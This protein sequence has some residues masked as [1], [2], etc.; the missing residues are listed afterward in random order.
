VRSAFT[1]GEISSTGQTI[2]SG[3]T[4]TEIGSTTAASGGDASITYS[5]RSSADGYTAAIGSATSAT[6]TPPSGLT[7]TTSYRRYANDGTCNT[8]ATVSTGTWTVTVTAAPNAGTISGIQTICP[9]ATTTFSSNGDAGAWS[10]GST[11][12][13][14]VNSSTGVI[15][16]VTGG[17]ATITYTVIGTGGCSNAT[18]TR[19]VTVNQPKTDI[20]VGGVTISNGN[21][22]W[23][24]ASS[25]DVSVLGNWYK[26]SSGAF[27]VADQ[28]PT[29]SD[30]VFIVPHTVALTCVSPSNTPSI[31]AS[32]SLTTG[33]IY[34]DADATLS[35]GLSSSLNVAGN[36]I[37]DGVVNLTA[38][39]VTFSGATAQTIGGTGTTIFNNLTI[40]NSNGV[41]LA[42]DVSVSAG[43][44]LS[45]GILSLG[46]YNL[47]IGNIG[48]ISVTSPSS[49]KMISTSGTGELRKHYAQASN[50]NPAA[51]LFPVG[52]TGEFTPVS[53]DFSDVDFGSDAYMKVRVQNAK[54]TAMSGSVTSYIDRTWIVEPSADVTGFEYSIDL[55]YVQADLVLTNGVVESELLPVKRS[56]G[57]WYQP[58]VMASTFVNATK[59]GNPNI[60]GANNVLSWGQLTTFSEFGGAGGD[61]VPLPVELLSFSGNCE[62]E[63]VS[64]EWKT[65]S[66][67]NSSYFDVEKSR[68]GENWNLLTTVP[69]AGNSV[70]LLTYN[71]IDVNP[72]SDNNYYRLK[73]VDIDG[74]FK[75]YDVINVTC[76]ETTKGYFSSFPNP[77]GDQFQVI[78]NDKDLVGKGTMNIFDSK[79]TLISKHELELKDGINMFVINERF[80]SGIY[81]INYTV[82]KKSTKVL[83]HVVR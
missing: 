63:K 8:T 1:S 70:S 82:G 83:K 76:T 33:N 3:G 47:T 28:A 42:N 35:L 81:F 48:S 13:A 6:Y 50:Q 71:A 52:T 69:A 32:G 61:N 41:S 15:T 57:Q 12:V 68:D 75:M 21:Y 60:D 36:F 77:S 43:L 4:P 16:G 59:Q 19:T 67:H 78:I 10:S 27:I 37:N 30:R 26:M 18:A 46:N 5:W 74:Q 23:N 65:A 79:G 40:N 80:E 66:E 2:C 55:Q 11:G 25:A 51:F 29:N 34:I 20:T 39:T 64:L 31:S 72:T 54:N 7:A 14:T 73:Q 45:S 49:S 9:N 38:G 56:N 22:L 24:G 17:A 53:L 62:D 44:N 58:N